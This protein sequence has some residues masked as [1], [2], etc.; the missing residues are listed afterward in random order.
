MANTSAQLQDLAV[1]FPSA[2]RSQ[3]RL[4]ASKLGIPVYRDQRFRSIVTGHSGPS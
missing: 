2:H 3:I 1:T 4:K